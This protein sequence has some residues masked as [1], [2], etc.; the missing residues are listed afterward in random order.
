M[1]RFALCLALGL[2][3]CGLS[4]D[5][6][7][8]DDARVGMDAGRLD[9][10]RADCAR[11]E[12]CDDD[13]VCNGQ[14][15][16]EAGACVSGAA[17]TCDDGVECTADEC[18]EGV[19]CVRTPDHDRCAALGCLAGFCDPAFGCDLVAP[20][21][22]CSDGVA[23]TDDRCTGDGEC[24]HLPDDERC[25]A[26]QVCRDDGCGPPPSCASDADCGSP[27]IC[28]DG[29][30]CEGGRC[31]YDN[32]FED[33]RCASGDPC[34]RATC[35]EGRCELAPPVDCGAPDPSLCTRSECATE[36][37]GDILCL[38]VDRDGEPCAG[39]DACSP[40]MCDGS[41]CD[42]TSTC[43]AADACETASCQPDGTCIVARRICPMVGQR[44]DPA[45]GDC[46]ANCA[47]GMADCDGDGGCECDRRTSWCDG[48]TCRRYMSCGPCPGSASECCPCTGACFDPMCLGCCMFCPAPAMAAMP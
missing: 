42:S 19:G 10:G 8:P 40:G 39:P 11:D 34:V 15:R 31:R 33:A 17:P 4:L 43:T 21:D 37:S 7:P 38:T 26:D 32:A 44:C 12:D 24:L 13:Q 3:G 35:D 41:T 16:C 29:G 48:S 9:G 20:D 25:P 14:E 46:V 6:D 45:T 47:P 18:V 22:I 1:R 23:C 30:R 28:K 36:A 27:P 2:S 5:F